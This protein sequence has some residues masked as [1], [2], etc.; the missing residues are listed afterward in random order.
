MERA[1]VLR[2]V[3][4]SALAGLVAP[5]ISRLRSDGVLAFENLNDGR[6]RRHEFNQLA[7]E[8]AFLVHGVEAFSFAAAHPDALGSDNAKASF[9]K[10][11]R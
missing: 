11:L 2:I 9:L 8:R 10:L 6:S 7:E 5:M 4:S 1:K 3:P